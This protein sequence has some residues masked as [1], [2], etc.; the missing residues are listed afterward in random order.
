M[1]KKNLS[2]PPEFPQANSGEIINIPDIIA[3]HTNYVMMKVNK[4]E[5]VAI[6]DTI[7]EEI[8]LKNN[9]KD[10]VKSI[11][12]HVAP[13]QIG[14]DFHVVLFDIDKINI[15]GLCE[16]QHTV[17]SSVRNNLYS[18]TANITILEGSHIQD[19]KQ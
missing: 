8:Y 4:Y 3:M 16:A 9:T 2:S 7:K 14:N 13:D 12:Y 18:K 19:L 1:S 10:K 6:L 15:S 11:P 5:G 17:K